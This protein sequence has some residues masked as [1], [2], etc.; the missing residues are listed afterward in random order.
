[1]IEKLR[2]IDVVQ[3]DPRVLRQLVVD[4][5]LDELLVNALEWGY[6]LHPEEM[7][8]PKK[9]LQ[10]TQYT[11]VWPKDRT[12]CNGVSSAI[13]TFTVTPSDPIAGIA[14]HLIS[15]RKLIVSAYLE[16]EFGCRW[17]K[18]TDIHLREVLC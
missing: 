13:N 11:I 14:E 5:P 9:S 4:S 3:L 16:V 17:S 2:P 12:I 10:G 8:S 15:L 1:M 7:H 18:N 6:S